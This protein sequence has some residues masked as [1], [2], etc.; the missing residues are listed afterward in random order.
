MSFMAAQTAILL[1]GGGLR[2]VDHEMTGPLW[3]Y[4]GTAARLL[5]LKISGQQS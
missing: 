2:S 4:F 1:N 5:D 3:K